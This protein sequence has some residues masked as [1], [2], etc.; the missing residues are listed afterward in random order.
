MQVYGYF[1]RCSVLFSFYRIQNTDSA[2]YYPVIYMAPMLLKIRFLEQT[3]AKS[4][5]STPLMSALSTL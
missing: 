4:M 1:K 3:N 2:P 5:K